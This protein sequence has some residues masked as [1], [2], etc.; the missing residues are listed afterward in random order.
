[1]QATAAA[2][3]GAVWPHTQ[4]PGGHFTFLPRRGVGRLP[5]PRPA[6]GARGAGPLEEV[7][8]RPGQRPLGPNFSVSGGGHVAAHWSHAH[9]H[10]HTGHGRKARPV[11]SGPRPLGWGTNQPVPLAPLRLL[12]LH[13][14]RAAGALGPSHPVTTGST[15]SREQ[16]GQAGR[17]LKSAPHPHPHQGPYGE[18]TAYLLGVVLHLQA[19][20]PLFTF[21]L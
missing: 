4:G 3:L 21:S 5:T 19:I 7:G 1:M 18:D 8:S 9:A 12:Q 15:G 13:T 20:T 17:G 14:G 16:L 11:L 6:A 2:V 10:R